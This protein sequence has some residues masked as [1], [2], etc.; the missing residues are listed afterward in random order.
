MSASDISMARHSFQPQYMLAIAGIA[1]NVA[2]GLTFGSIGL[3]IE[4]LAAELQGSRSTISLS[5]SLIILM[6][7]LLGPL[8]GRWVDRWSLRGTMLIGALLGAAG[9]YLASRATSTA[10]FLVCYGLLVGIGFAMIGVLPANKIVTLWFPRSVGRAS[11][12]V[13]MPLAIALLPPLFATMLRD[14]GWRHLLEIFALVYV[15]LFGLLL[16]LRV[17]VE[18]AADT[19]VADGAAAPDIAPF[20]SRIFWLLA[21]IIGLLTTSGIVATTHVVPFAQSV[22]IAAPQ[23]AVLLSVSGIFSVLGAAFYGWLCDRITPLFALSMIAVCHTAAWLALAPQHDFLIIAVLVAVLG[24]GGGGLMPTLA[25][26]LGR[27]FSAQ[28]FGRAF[29]QM[30][31]ATLPFTFAAAP[32]IGLGYDLLGNYRG[33]FFLQM[34]I[35][36]AAV[37]LLMLT[38]SALRKSLTE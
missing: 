33:A 20:R 8:V 13:N 2:T 37:A 12:I 27:I 28:Q 21:M 18:T 36:G 15:A 1:Q 3:L 31:F 30:N 7:G 24:L 34:L 4:P 25:A 9:F 17:P 14:T 5:I 23:A 35:C 29:G 26:L 16:L 10:G 11:A 19:V 22:A 38:R 32:L 6:M